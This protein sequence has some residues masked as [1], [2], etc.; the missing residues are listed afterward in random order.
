MSG[1]IMLKDVVDWQIANGEFGDEASLDPTLARLLRER[2]EPLRDFVYERTRPNGTVLEV[3]SQTLP[4]GGVVC[5]YSDITERKANEVALAEAQARAAHAERMQALGQL[6]GGIAHDFNNILQ[7]VQGAASLIDRRAAGDPETTRRFT[8]M[9]LEATGRGASITRR[10]LSFARRGEL[11]AEAVEPVA[12][13]HDLRDIL[14][15]TLGAAITVTVDS[16]SN[17][18]AV[19]ADKGQLET[20]LV[21]LATNARDAMPKGGTLRFVVATE[22]V[23]QAAVHPADLRP[24]HYVRLSISDNG[25][26]MS[27]S[28]LARASE[29]FFTTKPIGQGT[30]LGLSMVKGF[31]EQSGGGMTIASAPGHGTVVTMWLP[32]AEQADAAAPP[33]GVALPVRSPADRPRRVVLVDDEAMV[34]D[35]LSAAL[36]DAGYA[37][38]AL[39]SGSEA[40]VLLRSAESVD[41]LVSDLSMPGMDGLTVIREAQRIRPGLP[42]VLLTGYAGHGAQLAIGGALERSF[43]LVRKPVAIGQLCDRIEALLAVAPV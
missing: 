24:G 9:I 23:T 39:E 18:P 10:L 27:R 14:S 37:I 1:R 7:A 43:A 36:T 21:N 19:L 16:A 33:L 34:R 20:A 28:A 30:G 6:A 31:A 5:T 35:T 3:R 8:R 32:A 22:I 4:N 29:P 25:T 11:R 2:G 41:V 26:G 17:L 12:L 38:L 13:L 42:A 40:L 15:H